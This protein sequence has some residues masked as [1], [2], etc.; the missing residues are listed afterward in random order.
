MEI[1]LTCFNLKKI[2]KSMRPLDVRS[3]EIMFSEV[4]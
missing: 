3:L 4:H 2:R 1:Q